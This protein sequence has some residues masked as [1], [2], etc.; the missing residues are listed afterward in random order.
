MLFI[1]IKKLLE[2]FYFD[3]KIDIKELFMECYLEIMDI[4]DI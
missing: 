3:K 1:E 4:F 2:G